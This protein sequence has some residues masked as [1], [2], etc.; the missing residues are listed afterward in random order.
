MLI[1]G[2][3]LILIGSLVPGINPSGKQALVVIGIILLCIGGVLLVTNGWPG[4][5]Y[6]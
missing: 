2:L 1:L 6:Y 5:R 4:Y 3:I